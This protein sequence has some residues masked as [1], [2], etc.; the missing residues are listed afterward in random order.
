MEG[1]VI[2]IYLF[3]INKTLFY[4]LLLARPEYRNAS[5]SP[6]KEKLYSNTSFSQQK[7]SNSTVEIQIDG[8]S[9]SVIMDTRNKLNNHTVGEIDSRA[10]IN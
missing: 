3:F 9:K 2:W 4:I 6:T 7:I 8:G 1:R 5:H 10:N